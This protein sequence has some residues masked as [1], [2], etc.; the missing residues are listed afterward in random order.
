MPGLTD[1]YELPALKAIFGT[2]KTIDFPAT[3]YLALLSVLPADNGTGSS[4]PTGVAG[5]ARQ[6]IANTNASWNVNVAPVV[7]INTISFPTATANYP[8]P[9]VGWAL[10]NA[11]TGGSLVFFSPITSPATFLSGETPSFSPGD[12][13]IGAD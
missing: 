1:A 10:F 13:S 8:A 2:G 12:L 3:Y 9:I 11:L 7:N 4:E 5:Y 6:A